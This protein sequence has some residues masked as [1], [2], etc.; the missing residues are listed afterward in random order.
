VKLT[1]SQR[2][3]I[4]KNLADHLEADD[5]NEIDLVLKQFNLPWTDQW[6][7]DKKGYIVEM[8]GGVE[9]SDLRELAEHYGMSAIDGAV[10]SVEPDTPYWEE[11]QLK[12]FISHLTTERAQAAEIQV[13][14][15]KYAMSA[16]VAHNDIPPT[17]EWQVEIETALATCDLLVA[18]IHP[19]FVNSKWCDQEIG[20]A[21]GRG[22]PVFTVRCGEDPHGFVSKFQSLNGNEKTSQQIAT[23]I[24]DAAMEHKK[25]R[26]KIADIL[27]D[28]FVNSG[29]FA[30]AKTRI[31]Y[32]ERLKFWD[33]S[34]SKRLSKAVDANSQISGAFGVSGQIKALVEKW[35]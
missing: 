31:S 27:V 22:I 13:A 6:S 3:K 35:K 10:S 7:G 15:K 28:F 23:L 20:Y 33:P 24:F 14:L 26:G 16:F 19:N 30:S 12:V 21:L 29:S 32:L 11:G 4:I 5:W 34:Y 8:I 25:L 18:L 1:K 2:V 9:D 17:V